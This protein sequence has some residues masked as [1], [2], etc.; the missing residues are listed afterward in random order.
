MFLTLA[1]RIACVGFLAAWITWIVFIILAARIARVA[2]VGFL[3]AWITWIGNLGARVARVRM[4]R[5]ARLR[6][7]QT[8]SCNQE[9]RRQKDSQMF[10]V[11]KM[12]LFKVNFQ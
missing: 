7:R 11:H 2:C 3:A 10:C 5:V 6:D 8:Y 1:A 9:K 4:S 12:I